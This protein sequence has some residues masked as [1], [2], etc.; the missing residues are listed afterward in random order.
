MVSLKLFDLFYSKH[1]LK[2]IIIILEII[3]LV[4]AFNIGVAPV[5]YV[6]SEI[7]SLDQDLRFDKKDLLFFSSNAVLQNQFIAQDRTITEELSE[8]IKA[9]EHVEYVAKMET[10]SVI[11]TLK[12]NKAISA[13]SIINFVSE[14]ALKCIDLH[15]SFPE[16]IENEIP[17]YINSNLAQSL[18]I[19][20]RIEL[21][22]I[23][24]EDVDNI[25]CY[26]Y[27]ILEENYS[28]FSLGSRNRMFHYQ[29][30]GEGNYMIAPYRENL[31]SNTSWHPYF[32][33]K[34]KDADHIDEIQAELNQEFSVFGSF[35]TMASVMN[36]QI[37]RIFQQEQWSIMI[38]FLSIIVLLFSYGG[39]LI[40]TMFNKRN[41]YTLLNIC[42]AGKAKILSINILYSCTIVLPA[43]IL[44]LIITPFALN[45]FT[46]DGFLGYN[47]M[48][49]LFVFFVLAYCLL[50]PVI[51]TA[52]QIRKNYFKNAYSLDE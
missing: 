28:Y 52:I 40:F 7:K 31:H 2:E 9:N 34:T 22:K 12:E 37:Q 27:G 19:G 23:S 17:V 35:K 24:E 10:P 26:V 36:A 21:N 45:E 39:Y 18:K 1:L 33:I 25:T 38:M 47:L 15:L 41:L 43:V 20:D 6:F 44:A 5:G 32:L 3:V 4:I 16:Q 46:Y 48:T 8:R 13:S 42:G 51:F 29:P 49:I 30:E 50:L 11:F 14:D